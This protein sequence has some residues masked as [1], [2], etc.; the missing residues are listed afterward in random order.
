MH[1]DLER[2]SE[3]LTQ[4]VRPPNPLRPIALRRSRSNLRALAEK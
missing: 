1:G 3:H 4:G 2:T